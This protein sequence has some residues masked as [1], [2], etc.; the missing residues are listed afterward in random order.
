MLVSAFYFFNCNVVSFETV[1][2]IWFVCDNTKASFY[3]FAV[4]LFFFFCGK[5]CESIVFLFFV[6]QR[7]M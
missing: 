7:K 2:V 5:Y 6:K 4:F 1:E 3:L